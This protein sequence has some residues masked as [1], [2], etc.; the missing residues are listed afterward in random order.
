MCSTF[1]L[2]WDVQ[3][4]ETMQKSRKCKQNMTTSGTGKTHCCI[5]SW[6][7]PDCNGSR[8]S[9]IRALESISNS[10]LIWAAHTVSHN[11]QHQRVECHF[12]GIR[13]GP[14]PIHHSNVWT[15]K[16]QQPCTIILTIQTANF[17]Q[18]IVR[19]KR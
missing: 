1:T 18:T 3:W 9:L 10:Y 16:S 15:G 14:R 13:E 12:C 2:L 6:I 4:S 5:K 19:H 17:V 11:I 7:K 8:Q